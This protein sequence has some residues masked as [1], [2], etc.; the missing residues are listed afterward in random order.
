M[1]LQRLILLRHGETGWNAG[2]RMQGHRDIPLNEQ[3][4][5]QAAQAAPSV[6]ALQP[7]VIVASDL[8]RAR[9]TAAEVAALTGLPVQLDKRLRETSLGLWEGL[10]PDEVMAGWP[11][12]WEAWRA[13][14]AHQG[15]PEGESRS[16][17]A[18]R[19][20]PVVDELD[21]TGLTRA[22]LV[23]H[24]GLIIGLTGYL[25]GLP[26]VDWSRMIGVGN[27]HW[28]VLERHRTQWRLRSY[29][30]GLS[31]M[32]FSLAEDDAEG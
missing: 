28:V 18:L 3:G 24:G 4:R 20:A 32:V 31:G 25:L 14:S 10:T 1:T 2:M 23:A 13:D 27:C 9:D 22:L 30:A 8:S 21:R 26:A 12:E 19:S 29:N 5:R 6:A 11:A 7:Q 17:V 16:Q 15:P